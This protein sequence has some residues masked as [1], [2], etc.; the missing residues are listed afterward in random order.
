[1]PQVVYIFNFHLLSKTFCF[2]F[3]VYVLE[4][5]SHRE[6][7]K[8]KVKTKAKTFF[9][10]CHSVFDLFCFAL[11]WCEYVNRSYTLRKREIECSTQPRT[12]THHAL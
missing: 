5:R 4:A 7:A 10:V 3:Q 9:D 12:S 11:A 1:M 2:T 6:K 8:E